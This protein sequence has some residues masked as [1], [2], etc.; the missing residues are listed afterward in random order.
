MT[1][2]GSLPSGTGVGGGVGGAGG[3]LSR[4]GTPS[5]GAGGR[6]PS[7]GKTEPLFSSPNQPFEDVLLRQR[8]LGQDIIPSPLQPK[9]TESL[10]LPAKPAT[11]VGMA[12]GGKGGGGGGGGGGG[13]KMKVSD[14][15]PKDE[16]KISKITL[17]TYYKP[18]KA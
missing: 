17:R 11:P 1:G 16:S 12:M 3:R 14:I 18:R 6:A 9:R 15:G 2:N 7:L 4:A 13:K 10:Y 8:T 5:L